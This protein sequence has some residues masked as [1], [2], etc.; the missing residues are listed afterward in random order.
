M[1]TKGIFEK[2]R[3][4]RFPN[5]FPNIVRGDGV[6]HGLAGK[7]FRGG[8]SEDAIGRVHQ[9]HLREDPPREISQPFPPSMGMKL[10]I[11]VGLLS[12]LPW[13]IDAPFIG[14]TPLLLCLLPPTGRR[15]LHALSHRAGR[16]YPADSF[17]TGCTHQ[18]G[19]KVTHASLSHRQFCYM[20]ENH[21]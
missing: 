9:G 12:C 7:F 18:P 5:P 16:P 10:S 17:S 6:F 14:T 4:E 19:L 11:H 3:H 15:A 1:S 2:I 13:R 8:P 20:T 21:L